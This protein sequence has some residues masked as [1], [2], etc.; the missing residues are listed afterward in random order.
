MAWTCNSGYDWPG[1]SRRGSTVHQ[2]R[3][4]R[5][6]AWYT[7]KLKTS[8]NV[9]GG[10]LGKFPDTPF[11]KHYWNIRK[12]IRQVGFC[13]SKLKSYI[14][15]VYLV[16]R[17]ISES[18]F[19]SFVGNSQFQRQKDYDNLIRSCIGYAVCSSSWGTLHIRPSV[20]C[21]Q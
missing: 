11:T 1:R 2:N 18:V 13:S 15:N 6:A 8:C 17:H 20:E 12:G 16:G 7:V 5:Y 19:V 3:L 10:H 14:C 4:P 21:Y 9:V